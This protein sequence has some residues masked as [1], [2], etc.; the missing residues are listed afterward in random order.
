MSARELI[1]LS[2]YRL[3]GQHALFLSNED[4]A[5]FLNGL[6]A[7]WHP[8]A[9]CGAGRTPHIESP[10][11]HEQPVSGHIYCVPE[12]PPLVLPDDWDDRVR[13]AG[14]VV[15]RATGDRTQTLAN[16][17]D[18]LRE[19]LPAEQQP[20]LESGLESTAPFFGLGFGH[21]MLLTLVE[22][23]EHEDPLDASAFWQS[24]Q[25]AVDALARNEPA[26]CL[27][28]LQEAAN[29]ML[30]AREVLYSASIYLLDL[31]V[32]GEEGLHLPPAS[33]RKQVSLSMVAAARL[34][35]KL[36]RDRPE[37]LEA[38]KQGIQGERVEVCGGPFVERED[39]LLPIE[40]QVWN[41]LHGLATYKSLLGQD[42][43]VF[44]RRRFAA[45]PQLPLLLNTVGLRRAIFLPF[46]E[47]VLPT[48]RVTVISLPS[49]DG[50]QVDAFTRPPYPA[51]SAQTFFHFAHY[52]RKTIADDH[53]ATLA[54]LHAKE[55]AGPWYDDLLELCRF[56]PILGQW[57]TVS[58]YLNDVMAGEYAST[59]S[60]DE[61]HGDY[62][63]ERTAVHDKYPVSWFATQTR[64]RRRL[65]TARTLT[66]ILRGLAGK[67]A[68]LDMAAQLGAVEARIEE[69]GADDAELLI[70]EKS[71]EE[72]VAARLLVRATADT[73]GFLFLNPCAFTRRLALELENMQGALP[74]AGPVKASQLNGSRASIVVE[75]PALGF[76]WIPQSGPAGATP[77]ASRMKMADQHCVRNEFFEAEVD[78][79]TG[80]LRGLRDHR[81]RIN[82]I[83]QQ[84]VYNPGS[85]MRARE[86]RVTSAGP[87]LGELTSEGS[88]LDEHENVQATY[89]QKLRAWAGRPLLEMQIEIVPQKPVEGYAWHAYYGARFAW[90]DERALLLR[91]VN[92]TGYLTSHTRPETPDYLELRQARQSTLLLPGG[93]PFHQRH[94][95]RMLDIILIC[96]GEQAQ[97]FDLALALDRD[98]PMQTALGMITPVTY[99]PTSK[100]PPHVGQSG[101]LFHLD[102][103]NLLLTSM[104]PAS[105]GTDAVIARL[106]ECQVHTGQA[107]LRCPRNP[108]RAYFVDAQG[109]QQ[110]D[111][112]TS[113]DAAL[114]EVSAGDLAHLRVDFE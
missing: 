93:L 88:I 14:A 66:G 51:E 13:D 111:A 58:R 3:P 36:E 83:G 41:L 87:A 22:A 54:F 81:T 17:R 105:D 76:A 70:V 100:G 26:G 59:P 12:S 7:L 107:E 30:A 63:S 8:A 102:A 28:Q 96:E 52:L 65:D 99:V 91:G 15:F 47:A 80:G 72:A 86:I 43:Q 50:K 106:L 20:L 110:M 55:V 101:W 37:I 64:L 16:L 73:P 1:L 31:W 94:G 27:A 90:R 9:L 2:P 109:V 84:I 92:G 68:P 11:D 97:K 25:Q 4:C 32:P 39:A 60:P 33:L 35:L 24:V 74:L 5:A 10:Y 95:S 69:T 113:D 34:L 112:S 89:R 53:S 62:L 49:P 85:T 45:H 23:M 77:A 40:S 108:Q 19:K 114:F 38:I 44:G 98:Y 71:I 6:A 78:P 61:F 29:R 104:S 48:Y 56:G 42:I 79:A 82:R 75:V 18:A 21:A 67:R 103:P 46:D 57:T